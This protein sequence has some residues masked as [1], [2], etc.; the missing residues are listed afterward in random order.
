MV[1]DVKKKWYAKYILG[2]IL[3]IITNVWRSIDLPK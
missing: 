3:K 1:F 2:N